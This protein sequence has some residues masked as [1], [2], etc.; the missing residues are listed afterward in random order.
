MLW[1]G[2]Q[3]WI[4]GFEET[5]CR[6]TST[7]RVLTAMGESW[8]DNP[9]AANGLE[10]GRWPGCKCKP[11]GGYKLLAICWLVQVREVTGLFSTWQFQ[12]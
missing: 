10:R 12:G 9:L 4:C 1:T 3:V 7:S 5:C 8:S 2:W 6:S 11:L